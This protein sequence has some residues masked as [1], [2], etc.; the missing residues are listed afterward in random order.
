M[1]FKRLE[2]EDFLI[3]AE[4][5]TGTV[6]TGNIPTLISMFTS[7]AQVASNVGD[8]FY[9]IYSDITLENPEFDLVYC[10]KLGSGSFLYNESVA[11]NSPSKT[12]Y[13]QYRNL[14]LGDEN[15]NLVFGNYTAEN[16]YALSV[17][18]AN[19]KEKLFPNN[20]NLKL[21]VGANSVNL[22]TD[23]SIISSLT[24]KDAGRVY[25]LVSGSSG[26]VYTGVNSTGWAG[27]STG[28][29]GS[30]GWFLPDIG[31]MLFNAA[32]LDGDP[33]DGGISLGTIR[34]SNTNDL[35]IDKIY[36]AISTGASFTL[37]NEETLTSTYVFVRPRNL[38]FNYSTNP[39]YISGSTGELTHNSF[40]DNPKSFITTVGLYNDNNELLAVAKLSR[41]LQ[42]DSVSELLLRTKLD[43]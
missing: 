14:I 8:F 26:T 43:F 11:E 22:T 29:S 21:T 3:S 40:I 9:T 16:F 23:S 24:F 41:P 1:S 31:V 19:Y 33:S 36:S 4:S 20:L 38:E 32:A 5:T 13:G 42:K 30:Y 15:A 35:N 25:N 18:R 6:W 34:S 7:S 39:S 2:P 37:N 12:M 17:N 28:A 10:D 27:G